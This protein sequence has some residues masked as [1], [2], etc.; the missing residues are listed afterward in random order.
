VRD[1]EHEEEKAE[2]M[3]L[4]KKFSISVIA[5][6]VL[7]VGAMAGDPQKNTDKPPPPP[8]PPQDVRKPPKESPPPPRDNGNK[9]NNEGKRGGKP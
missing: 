6:C 2:T 3:K 7:A 9:G 4:L 8:K 5:S 1:G